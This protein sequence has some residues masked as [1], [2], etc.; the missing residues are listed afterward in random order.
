MWPSV[1]RTVREPEPF[2]GELSRTFGSG[3]VRNIGR[4]PAHH[5][6]SWKG[7]GN[8]LKALDIMVGGQALILCPFMFAIIQTD[9]IRISNFSLAK[10]D[11]S[12]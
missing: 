9:K 3:S 8:F 6:S 2:C 12:F 5:I 1:T 11:I 4:T 10:M 7:C